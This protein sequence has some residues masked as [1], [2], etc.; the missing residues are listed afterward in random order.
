MFHVEHDR[1]RQNL[2]GPPLLGPRLRT[3]AQN[4]SSEPGSLL[5]DRRAPRQDRRDRADPS[6]S[7][8]PGIPGPDQGCWTQ[9]QR[10]RCHARPSTGRHRWLRDHQPA[11][12]AQHR[13]G[14]LGD[15]RRGPEAP[16]HDQVRGFAT[17]ARRP[18]LGPRRDD[19]D[20]GEHGRGDPGHGRSQCGRPTGHGVEQ[21]PT[22]RREARRQD[23]TRKP[24]PRAEVDA[25]AD[26]V[27]V[28]I[29]AGSHHIGAC[30]RMVDVGLDGSGPEK[31][32]PTGLLQHGLD[33]PSALGVPCGGARHHR[34]ARTTGPLRGAR[35]RFVADPGIGAGSRLPGRCHLRQAAARRVGSALRPRTR[36]ARR[37][38]S[39]P[40]CGSPCDRRRSWA[41]WP[42]ARRNGAPRQRPGR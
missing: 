12:D 31:T 33:G 10:R 37:R 17:L 11:A 34:R 35:A 8:E 14:A 18:L 25:V 19:A 22:N 6:E 23:Q 20:A 1:G 9:P 4:R 16:G 2:P 38:W 40:G 39:P 28:E 29:E 5:H 27:R 32:E 42:D 24:A 7:G 26:P 30:H 21:R 3:G 41:P 13:C 36:S 15:D